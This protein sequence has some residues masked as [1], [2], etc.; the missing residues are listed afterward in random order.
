M[1]LNFTELIYSLSY[2]LDCVEKD[3][4]GVKSD[5]GKRVACMS[6]FMAKDLGIQ[7]NE[8]VEF[9]G[10]AVL[11]DNAIAEY[12][13]E[14]FDNDYNKAKRKILT[15]LN[16]KNLN[17]RIHC[18]AGEENISLLP[19]KTNVKNI[20]LYHHGFLGYEKVNT[21]DVNYLKSQII[22]ISDTADSL[23]DI[24]RITKFKYGFLKFI[25]KILAGKMYSRETVKLF[26]KNV[27]FEKLKEIKDK[28]PQ[29]IL[30][31]EVPSEFEEYTDEEIRN[32]ALTFAKVVDYKSSFTK[33]HSIG[34]ATKADKMAEYYHFEKEQHIRFYFA[35]ALHDIGKLVI[36]ND[37]LEKKGS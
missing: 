14:E 25:L 3:L 1:K 36:S 16:G 29:K 28:G 7:G 19:F 23:V 17:V 21:S 35:A 26:L 22:S 9:I 33:D 34:V 15:N 11:H 5:H 30:N 24:T 10:C 27:T 32:I 31:E 8:L 12:I 37:I 4:S 6:L 20:I 2:G 18:V 13:S